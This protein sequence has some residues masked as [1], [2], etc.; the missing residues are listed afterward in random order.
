MGDD[1]IRNHDGDAELVCEALQ[2]AEEFGEVRLPRGELPPPGEIGAVEG[3]GAVD[4]EEREARL[5]HHLAG[6]GEELEL[7]VGVV[8]A[9]V[10]NVVKDLFTAQPVAVRDGEAAHGAEGPFRVDVQAFS[11]APAHV[12]GELAC[13]S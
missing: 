12:E 11:L 7:M 8:G 5:A 3:S 4:D 10:G 9:G 2:R 1:L 13:H 6:L